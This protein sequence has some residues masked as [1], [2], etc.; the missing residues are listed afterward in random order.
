[1]AKTISF[2][3]NED[4]KALALVEAFCLSENYDKRKL[5]GETK[6]Q[7]F[8]R[9]TWDYWLGK[10]TQSESRENFN[11]IKSTWEAISKS[12]QEA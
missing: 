3:I 2:T 11:T 5:E 6:N 4:A 8:R 9:M 12:D 7:F 1:M 10:A